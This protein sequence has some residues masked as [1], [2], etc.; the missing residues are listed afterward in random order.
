MAGY[1]HQWLRKWLRFE[2]HFII[3]DWQDP[4]LLRWYVLPRNHFLNI[5]LHKFIRSDDDRA[6]HDHPWSFLSWII[7]GEYIEHA[8]NGMYL[9][10]RW[11]IAYRPAKWL[12][13]VE[14]LRGPAIARERTRVR[15]VRPELPVWT[16]ILT[17]P[18]K[19]EWGFQCPQGW[20]H[21]E[22][23]VEAGCE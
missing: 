16:L 17:G 6:L 13:R 9:R 10:E 4:Y 11:S 14:L 22:H 8:D 23:F 7:K 3:G 5:Y 2:P 19:R 15:P 20:R 21:W 18:K 1:N 12:H